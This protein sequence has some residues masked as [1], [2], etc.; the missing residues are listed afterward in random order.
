LRFYRLLRQAMLTFNL[1]DTGFAHEVCTVAGRTPSLLNWDR[2]LSNPEAP[3][4]YTHEKIFE[5]PEHGNNFALLYESK[6]IVPAIYQHAPGVIDRF[7]AVFTHDAE[8]IAA[9]PDKCRFVPGGGI[10]IGGRVGGGEIKLYEKRALVS[11]VSSNKRMCEWHLRRLNIA[12]ALLD[13]PRVTVF[14]AGQD[15]RSPSWVPI[16]ETLADFRYSIVMENNQDS[17]YFTEKLLNCFATGTVP[18]YFGAKEIGR[19]F[20]PEG[21]ISFSSESEL[22]AILA[23]LSAEDY[24]RRRPAVERNFARCNEFLTIEDYIARVHFGVE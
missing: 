16:V 8:L 17:Y 18:I 20:D 21:I 9:R 10:W 14:I 4:F 3:T 23:S 1:V 7:R 15:N 2:S 22:P 12:L 11:M 5:A 24:E 19:I 6:A 13:D